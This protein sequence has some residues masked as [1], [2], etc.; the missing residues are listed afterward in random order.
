MKPIIKPVVNT[1]LERMSGLQRTAEAFRYVLLSIEFWVSPEGNIR[2]WMKANTRLAVFMAVPTFMAF[3]VVTVALWEIESWVNS[4]TTIAG[5]LIVLPVL[6]LLA[7]ISI[8]IVCRIIRVF[9]P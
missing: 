7:V 9:K 2:Q 8:T 4:L 1:Q 3:P 5:K 6:V